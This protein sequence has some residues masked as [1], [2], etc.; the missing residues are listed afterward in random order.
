VTAEEP[1]YSKTFG[2]ILDAA[3]RNE[4]KN[5]RYFNECG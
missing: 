2:L 3:Q 5:T 1:Q 4:P